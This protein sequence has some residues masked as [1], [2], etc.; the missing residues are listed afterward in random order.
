MSTWYA[1]D[2]VGSQECELVVDDQL[3]T[4]EVSAEAAADAFDGPGYYE[5][6][7][8]T[9]ED[10]RDVYNTHEIEISPE[11]KVIARYE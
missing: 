5:V 6:N 8:Y 7:W 10:L 1:V 9:L 2:Y 4:D 3:Y 11:L